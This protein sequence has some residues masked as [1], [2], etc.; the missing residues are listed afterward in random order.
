MCCGEVAD[1]K[2]EERAYTAA[3]AA[4]TAALAATAAGS[5]LMTEERYGLLL[6]CLQRP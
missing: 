5:V 4:A 6:G 1:G 3:V 2:W